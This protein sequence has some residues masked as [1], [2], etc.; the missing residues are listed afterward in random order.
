MKKNVVQDVVPSKKSIRNLTLSSRSG[1]SRAPLEKTIPSKNRFEDDEFTRPVAIKQQAPLRIEPTNQITS[2]I[3]RSVEAPSVPPRTPVDVPSYKYEYDEPRKS[4]KKWLYVALGV[5]VLAIAFGVSAFFKSAVIRVSPKQESVSLSGTF[6]A[7]KDTTDV[8]LLGFQVV[9]VSKDA[10]KTVEATGQQQVDKKAQGRIIIYNE[11]TQVQKLVATTRFE[12]PEGLVFRLP[13]AVSV[14]AATTKSG[15]T[16]AGSV[17]V[18][19]VADKTGASYN[20][21][22]KDFTLPG[23]KNDS[24]YKLIYARSKTEMTGGFSG[25]QKVVSKDVMDKADADLSAEL[26]ETLAKEIVSQIPSNFILYTSSLSYKF[27]PV[28]QSEGGESGAILRKRGTTS[29]VIFDKAALSRAILGK[30]APDSTAD[31][32][33]ITNLESLEFNYGTEPFDPASDTILS[34][35]LKGTPSLVWVFDENKLKTD[36]LGLSREKAKVILTTYDTVQEAWVETHP[37]WNQTIP[38]DATKVTI[39]NTLTK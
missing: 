33:K 34:F 18:L 37:F 10:E 38:K 21:G 24:K 3:N 30:V 36:L 28:E 26:K 9:T 5:L 2:Q 20:V 16:V 15:K 31:L 14:P 17:E 35:T 22:L 12:T 4:S 19:V 7:T 23:L 6:K 39:E 1:V 32:V 8:S 13:V 29:A 27:N 11:T 25:I